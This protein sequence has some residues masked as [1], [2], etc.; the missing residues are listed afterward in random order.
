MKTQR[1]G[2]FV[3]QGET[4]L[5]QALI[6]DFQLQTSRAGN[7]LTSDLMELLWYLMTSLQSTA[8]S[9]NTVTPVVFTSV[10]PEPDTGTT[11]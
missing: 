7:S 4:S 11:Q 2:T 1:E 3:N 10:V 8:S 9:T 5:A 6:L